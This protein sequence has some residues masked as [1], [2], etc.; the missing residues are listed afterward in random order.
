MP[1]RSQAIYSLETGEKL[2]LS[3]IMKAS[4]KEIK[5]KVVKEFSALMKREPDMLMPDAIQIVKDTKLSDMQYYLTPDGICFYFEPYV[6]AAYA[7]G[8]VEVTIPFAETDYFN[9][10]VLPVQ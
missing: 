5:D 10:I 8:F 4:E 6:L 1:Y 3:Q 2:G 7:A 9:P